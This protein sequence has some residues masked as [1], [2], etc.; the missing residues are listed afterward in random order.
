[1]KI[2][3]LLFLSLLLVAAPASAAG[4][5][6]TGLYGCSP[7]Q[8]ENSLGA[9]GAKLTLTTKGTYKLTLMTPTG[10]TVAGKY[11]KTTNKSGTK[12]K[13]TGGLLDGKTGKVTRSKLTGKAQ[14]QFSSWV[15]G[16][17][18]VRCRR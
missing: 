18:K 11:K 12:V 8:G 13:M 17:G 15:N 1:M 9:T 14:I 5:P 6:V 7:D 3:A 4:L 16:G 10:G 2:V